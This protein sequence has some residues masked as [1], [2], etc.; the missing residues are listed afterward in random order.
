MIN[1]FDGQRLPTAEEQQLEKDLANWVGQVS[2]R[3]PA[4][5]IMCTL[6]REIVKTIES[7]KSLKKS[8]I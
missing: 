2:C 3:S 7:G 8:D 1:V 6:Q 4:P 5:L